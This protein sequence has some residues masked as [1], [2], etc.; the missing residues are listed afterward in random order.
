MRLG[1]ERLACGGAMLFE[2][3]FGSTWLQDWARLGGCPGGAELS[4]Q[5]AERGEAVQLFGLVQGGLASG[6]VQEAM[7]GAVRLSFQP[8][9]HSMRMCDCHIH[10]GCGC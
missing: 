1:C 3:R 5:L 10:V 6:G 9:T 8:F 4:W 2:G 7:E